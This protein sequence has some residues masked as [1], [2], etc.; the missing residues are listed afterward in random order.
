MKKSLYILIMFLCNSSVFTQTTQLM[1]GATP[2]Y[3]NISGGTG[4]TPI[5]LVIGNPAANAITHNA[6]W[7]IS[8][9]QYNYVKWL[10][11]TP[12]S[13]T[14]PFG[15]STSAYL[16]LTFAKTA[17][18]ASD[19]LTSTWGTPNTN[20]P[21]AGATNVAA[22][23]PVTG[24]DDISTPGVD[25]SIPYVIDRWWTINTTGATASLAFTYRGEENTMS[26]PTD[27]LG[28]QHWNGTYWNNGNG[29]TWAT[30]TSTGTAGSNIAG[31]H[32]VALTGTFTEFSPYVLVSLPNPLPVE[33][34][35]ASAECM[36]LLSNL[37]SS[38]KGSVIV[39]WSTASEQN[40]DYF[41]V[42][43]SQD[44]INFETIAT[45]SASGNSNTV[46]NYSAIITEPIFGTSLYRVRE[47]DYDGK[48]ITTDLI[49]VGYCNNDEVFI[50][51][52]EGSIYVNITS[53]TNNQYAIELYNILGQKLD[54]QL[55][56]VSIGE[57]NFTILSNKLASGIYL[58]IVKNINNPELASGTTMKKVFISSINK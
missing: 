39:K 44:G 55:R 50:Y 17:G 21:W 11:T 35:N 5:Y 3:M 19:L 23:T 53:T 4:T 37:F 56:N 54:A 47:T 26:S 41:T 46:K 14:I 10:G 43:C 8:E 7:I 52:N 32:T 15:Y 28:I 29:G 6:G 27:I 34:L 16:P 25:G 12:V 58:V 2:T 49:T 1:L 13:Y 45:V 9:G 20:L 42:E 36:P 40:S 38:G 22:V 31:P 48:S 57:N 51:G 18:A 30:I 24:M 33:W